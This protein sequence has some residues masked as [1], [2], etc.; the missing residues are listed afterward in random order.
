MDIASREKLIPQSSGQIAVKDNIWNQLAFDIQLDVF[1]C[2]RA[3]DLYKNGRFASRH[4]YNVIE[5]H[6]EM[7]P[8]YRKLP[9]CRALNQLVIGGNAEKIQRRRNEEDK[10]LESKGIIVRIP[11]LAT[12]C[13]L[14]TCIT[15][16]QIC[17]NKCM[18]TYL[19]MSIISFIATLTAQFGDISIERLI[20]T[21]LLLAVTLQMGNTYAKFI[22]SQRSFFEDG[23]TIFGH[24][25]Y[26][27]E[28]VMFLKY[29]WPAYLA[30]RALIFGSIAILTCFTS[31]AA[32]PPTFDITLVLFYLPEMAFTINQNVNACV[33]YFCPDYKLLRNIEMVRAEF[34]DSLEHQRKS[35][36]QYLRST[37][38]DFTPPR[39][40]LLDELEL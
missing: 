20:S 13:M 37:S 16:Q 3:Y 26:S 8:K 1:Q 23:L 27:Y 18:T 9:D 31:L 40:W 10:I 36:R 39:S 6:K 24:H 15:W 35:C 33:Y 29:V 5:R 32:I 4:W 11:T 12:T 38:L 28:K 21:T 14:H 19:M 30:A 34:E 22:N 7:L 17:S 2:L 25:Y